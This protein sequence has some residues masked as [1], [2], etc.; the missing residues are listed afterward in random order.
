MAASPLV[1]GPGPMSPVRAGPLPAPVVV[2]VEVLLPDRVPEDCTVPAEFVPG[3]VGT[4]AEFPAPLGSL[5]ELLSPPTLAGPLGTPLVAAVPA[6]ADPAFGEPTA[7]VPA[8]GPLA[9]PPADPPPELL[10][11]LPP[12]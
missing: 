10:P 9:A 1:F 7:L 2:P 6:P 4:F 12:P 8:V 5:P 11:A 3:A